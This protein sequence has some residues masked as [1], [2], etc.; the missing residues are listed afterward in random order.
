PLA[1]AGVRPQ[2]WPDFAATVRSRARKLRA[3]SLYYTAFVLDEDGKRRVAGMIALER[4]RAAT[5]AARGKRTW[6]E[7]ALH[8]YVY[9]AVDAVQD[10]LSGGP[11]GNGLDVGFMTLAFGAMKALRD[12]FASEREF[13]IIPVLFVHPQFQRRGVGSALL[14]H[15]IAIVDAERMSMYVEASDAG[16]PLYSSFGF[17]TMRMLRIEYHDEVVL[18]PAMMRDA[19]DAGEL[20]SFNDT[21]KEEDENSVGDGAER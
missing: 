14:K 2:L 17:N 19:V 8:D 12:E 15:C 13:Y 4:P 20:P 1:R 18:I 21:T 3:G 9:P 6:K 7:R 16:A 11:N 10:R 5:K